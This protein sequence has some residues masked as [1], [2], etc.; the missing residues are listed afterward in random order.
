MTTILHRPEALLAWHRCVTTE[1]DF[2]FAPLKPSKQHHRSASPA[3]R[4]SRLKTD[5]CTLFRYTP[6]WVKAVV[7]T[8]PAAA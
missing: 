8:S 5:T 4:M 7:G 3:W 6:S 1:T 2:P